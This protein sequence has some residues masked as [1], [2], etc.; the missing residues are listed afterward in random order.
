MSAAIWLVVA[1]LDA[2]AGGRAVMSPVFSTGLLCR[3]VAFPE[4]CPCTKP[5]VPAICFSFGP[6]S[7]R[8]SPSVSLPPDSGTLVFVVVCWSFCCCSCLSQCSLQLSPSVVTL[9][10]HPAVLHL[11]LCLLHTCSRVLMVQPT[12]A[13]GV[14]D[15]PLSVRRPFFCAASS[16][17]NAAAALR[18][19]G[20]GTAV[21]E[22]DAFDARGV[23]GCVWCKVWA[24]VSACT[25]CECCCGD[26]LVAGA[27]TAVVETD[28]ADA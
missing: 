15:L 20:A 17:F 28:A 6:P 26:P 1:S 11:A 10:L 9:R 24:A 18:G 2:A 7:R 3:V 5:P 21:A 22:T 13:H 14:R 8:V 12:T 16:V 4:P 27:G 19:V 23:D 25:L